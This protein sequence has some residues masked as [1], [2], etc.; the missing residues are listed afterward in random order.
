MPTCP[1][2]GEIVMEGDPYCGNCGTTFNW[3]DDWQPSYEPSYGSGGY[4]SDL[5]ETERAKRRLESLKR[6]YENSLKRAREEEQGE[7]KVKYYGE[8]VEDA[9]KYWEESERCGCE[10][11][12]MPKMSRIL[13]NS[14]VDW[15]SDRHYNE[16]FKLH[17]L[18]RPEKEDLEN[19]LKATNNRNRIRQNKEKHRQR[20]EEAKRRSAVM[21]AI[22]SRENYFKHIEKGNDAALKNKFKKAVKE[23]GNAVNDYE[24]Y[25]KSGYSN[26]TLRDEMPDRKLT[27][28][29]V[30]NI[31]EIYKKTHPLLTSKKSHNRINS[32][33]VEMLDGEWDERLMVAD[34]EVREIL[35]QRQLKKEKRKEEIVDKGSDV[36]VG[37]RIVGDKIRG[38]FRK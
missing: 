12:G 15:I 25:F 38:M 14:D 6:T 8:A 28:E 22:Y 9:R 32:E 18:S 36:I 34:C 10:V 13:S 5:N 1:N 35:H 33:I 27:L 21:N 30:D 29:A 2:C 23:Y 26:D 37:A 17:I 4:R 24:A 31:L 11:D 3:A 16:D 20:H 7:F 19:I